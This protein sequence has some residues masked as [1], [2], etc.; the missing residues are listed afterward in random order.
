M[1][2]LRRLTS[3]TRY[4]ITTVLFVLVATGCGSSDEAGS[5]SQAKDDSVIINIEQLDHVLWPNQLNL[6]QEK[7]RFAVQNSGKDAHA[8]KIEGEGIEEELDG[9]FPGEVSSLVVHLHPGIYEMYCPIAR[10]QGIDMEGSITVRE[11]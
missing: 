6:P 8:F 9:Q 7:Y 3:L 2:P 4:F 11:A 5:E 1:Q 10:N